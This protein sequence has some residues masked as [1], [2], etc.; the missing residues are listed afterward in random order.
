MTATTIM[1]HISL[2]FAAY[3][4]TATTIKHSRRDSNSQI[5]AVKGRCPNLLDDKSVSTVSFHR[6][7]TIS[8]VYKVA[9]TETT[10]VVPPRFELG[11]LEPE[12][13]VLPLHHRTKHGSCNCLE[14]LRNR[15]WANL[16]YKIPFRAQSEL[17][18]KQ[19]GFE[20]RK[21]PL[22]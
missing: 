16:R 13:S 14:R 5:S 22:R 8:Y 1:A 15:H 12:S 3:E 21:P 18:E 20:P 10:I 11:T 2:L 7:A 19:Q 4:M 6:Q 17:C 9:S